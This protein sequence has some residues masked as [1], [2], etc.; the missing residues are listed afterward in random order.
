MANANYIEGKRP[1]IEAFRAE[2]PMRRIFM[3]DNIQQDSQVKDIQRKAR[4]NG[5]EVKLVSRKQLDEMS[6]RGSHQGLIAEAM[7]FGYAT[8][9]DITDAAALASAE[10]NGAALVVVLDHIT[11][12]GNLGAIARSAEIVGASGLIIPNKRSDSVTAATYKS[13]AG[14]INHIKIGRVANIVQT[15]ELLKKE[16]F[17]VCGSTEKAQQVV[18]DAPLHG[19][20]ALVMGN[21]NDGLA[22][23][24]MRSCDFFDKLPQV[25]S[26]GSLN[27]AQAATAMMYEWMRQC[28]EKAK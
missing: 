22:D 7:P 28:A 9:R 23:L 11:D 27:V 2:M 15:L 1:I 16:G 8:L 6:E 14:A 25:G 26:V 4:Q 24:T 10:N 20:I 21:E 12:S 19:K 3:A 5:V 17:W 13:Y 18:W